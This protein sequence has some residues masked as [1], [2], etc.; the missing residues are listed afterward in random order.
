[1]CAMCCKNLTGWDVLERGIL[2]TVDLQKTIIN[3]G[4]KQRTAVDSFL[5]T[6]IQIFKLLCETIYNSST[7]GK[8]G[9]MKRG[10]IYIYIY[11]L[12]ENITL[13]LLSFIVSICKN[14]NL[15]IYF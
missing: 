6:V 10:Y 11:I 9:N 14:S 1:M 2:S 5:T 4:V 3:L 8:D 13:F 15:Y 12:T 7:Q